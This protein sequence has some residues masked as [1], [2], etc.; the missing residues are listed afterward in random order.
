MRSERSSATIKYRVVIGLVVAGVVLGIWH[1]RR[2]RAGQSD[3]V[4]GIV[5][6][7]TVMPAHLF[8]AG[9]GWFGKKTEWIWKRQSLAR[10]NQR[11]RDE[12][13]ELRGRLNSLSEAQ[14]NYDRLRSDIGFVKQTR[15]RLLPADVISFRSDPKFDTM[16]IN[17]GTSD[18][19]RPNSVVVTKDGVV[20]RVFEAE[21]GTSTVLL[22]TDQRS[23]LGVRIQRP[24]SR[25]AAICE[26]DN[27]S[28]L[29]M[30]GMPDNGDVRV[31]DLVM[32]SGLG[33]VY[34]AGITVGT[35]TDLRPDTANGGRVIRVKPQVVFDR[36]EQVYVIR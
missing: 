15:P 18:G 34:P 33:G 27:T 6:Q 29:V 11:L 30:L 35:V 31:G 21:A 24:E 5:R 13:A 17:R 36:L 2:I 22:I 19:I 26:G 32:T 8:R 16:V 25:A 20:G 3:P 28:T 7:V 10:E 1:N 12:N 9:S 14:I 23:G 4:M